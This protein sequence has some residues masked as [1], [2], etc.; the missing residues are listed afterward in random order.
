MAAISLL[1]FHLPEAAPSP[2]PPNLF[3][4]PRETLVFQ[5]VHS[6]QISQSASRALSNVEVQHQKTFPKVHPR[7]PFNP[8]QS[9]KDEETK[10]WTYIQ[11][12]IWLKSIHA[13][14]CSEH[15]CLQQ[16]RLKSKLNVYQQVNGSE[17]VVY[18]HNGIL[19]SHKKMK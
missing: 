1:N 9:H 5:R 10:T 2:F 15:H 4:I 6:L 7:D 8:V 16:I 12:K 14:Q 17:N 19:F 18:I 11:R 13:P 3:I